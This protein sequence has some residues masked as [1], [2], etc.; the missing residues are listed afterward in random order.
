M[1]KKLT[2]EEQLYCLQY[3]F[4]I[5]SG[6]YTKGHVERWVP[7][8]IPALVEAQHLERYLYACNFVHNKNVLDIAGG[9][10][11]GTYLLGTKGNAQ[12]V[13]SVDLD[14]EAVKYANIKYHNDNI[15]RKV[16]NAIEY[17]EEKT[18]DLV[19]SFE[20]VEHL[21]NYE[22]FIH[23]IHQSL[24]ENGE[25]IISTPIT[26]Q[27]TTTPFNKYHVIEW[28]FDD[29]QE[30]IKK[31]FE[32]KETYVQSIVLKK[33]YPNLFVRIIRKLL[34]KPFVIN[35][36]PVFE[37]YTGQYCSDKMVSGYQMIH[38]VKK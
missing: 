35:E 24:K 32:I 34:N 14:V 25:L 2:I 6:L 13:T 19:V 5:L 33:D 29:F 22:K 18:Y 31:K 23:N 15:E 7:K 12:K 20:T 27:T 8:C 38:C 16:G 1:E 9:S 30:L 21:N 10:G 36:R 4:D 37:K 11:Y 28:S 17:V 26:S 3:E